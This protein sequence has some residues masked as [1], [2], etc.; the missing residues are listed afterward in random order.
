METTLARPW[1]KKRRYILPVGA[2]LG[3]GALSSLGGSTQ[4][5]E[6]SIVAPAVQEAALSA[7]IVSA[8]TSHPT[9]AT[10]TLQP[11]REATPTVRAAPT[12]SHTDTPTDSGLSN[13]NY[14]TNSSGNE[15][16]S[17]AY[18]NV[19]PAGASAQCGDGTYSFS[20]HR[21]GTCSH[22]GGVAEW[23]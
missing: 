22:H 5:S 2:I 1:Y 10:T 21:S 18:D 3:L 20:Q 7:P 8:T 16:H 15:V 23:L 19:V 4:P 12:V 9:A 17:P 6:Q 13:N 11:L 14:Y